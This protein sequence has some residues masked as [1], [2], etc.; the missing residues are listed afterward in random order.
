MKKERQNV[1]CSSLIQSAFNFFIND[2]LMA[3]VWKVI[4]LN[5]LCIKIGDIFQR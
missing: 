3:F 1:N 2:I 5:L 4:V